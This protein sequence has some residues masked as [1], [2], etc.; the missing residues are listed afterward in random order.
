MYKAALAIPALLLVV[1]STSFA[2]NTCSLIQGDAAPPSMAPVA[3]ETE[4]VAQGLQTPWGIAFLPET[5][6]ILVTERPG[7]LR[8]IRGGNV[9][10]SPVLE[11]KIADFSSDPLAWSG[12]EGGLLGI[13]L[14][15]RFEDNR[16]FYLYYTVNLESGKAVSRI[17]R[18]SLSADATG[19]TYDRI[20]MDNIPAGLHHQGGR[21]HI[22][23]DKMLY[24]GV[25][26]FLPDLAQDPTSLAGKL[27]RMDLEGAIPADNP[28]PTSYAFLSGIRNT[29]GFDWFD[30]D[31]LLVMDHGPSG[32]ELGNTALGGHDEFNV[33]VAGDN[34]GWPSVY[35]CNV[36]T[37]RTV[38][39]NVRGDFVAPVLTW[40][41][42]LPPSGAMFY[43]GND[44][45]E[46]K[47]SFL[48]T[49]LGIS[50]FS[51]NSYPTNAQ[52]LHRIVLDKKKPYVVES[53]EVYLKQDFGRLRTV[54]TDSRGRIYI[55]TSNCDG[56]GGDLCDA[57]GD[58]II[59]LKSAK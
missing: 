34:L 44:I 53:H 36:D 39:A 54:A 51:G 30:K 24:V 19:A 3:I 17:V 18:F 8:L 10:P 46:W 21:M 23:P 58:K 6:D 45:K 16:L 26:A 43:R 32:L 57:S 55:M 13:L 5:D 38:G 25:G 15:P 7:R 31:H 35:Q 42:A 27:L 33:A 56:R 14:H 49:T 20:I 41:G 28:D 59:R 22:G 29:Q 11:V 9:F 52:H 37:P 40:E 1:A 47:G 12:F 50:S 2:G 48:V 4:V